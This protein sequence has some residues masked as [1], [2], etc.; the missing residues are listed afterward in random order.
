MESS[1]LSY[2]LDNGITELFGIVNKT[3]F[4]QTR[5]ERF[6][7]ALSLSQSFRGWAVTLLVGDNSDKWLENFVFES[8][9]IVLMHRD[10][11]DLL[12]RRNRL[13]VSA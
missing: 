4:L 13:V 5:I 6:A 12:T 2:L 10:Q 8:L 7:N 9:D 1:F 3:S 11:V